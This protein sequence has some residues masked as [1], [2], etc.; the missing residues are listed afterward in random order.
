[1]AAA[2]AINAEKDLGALDWSFIF[3]LMTYVAGLVGAWR[4]RRWA[5]RWL[6]FSVLGMLLCSIDE[7]VKHP[8]EG[9]LDSVLTLLDGALLA[10]LW[11]APA[12][13]SEE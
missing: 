10:S 11:L 1:M 6:T 9:L 8:I 4:G 7:S 12:A 3:L 13:K 2:R 5:V